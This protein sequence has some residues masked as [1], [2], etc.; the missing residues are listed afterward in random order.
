MLWLLFFR[1][2]N[3]VDGLTYAEQLRR[4]YNLVPFYT[5]SN[6]WQVVTRYTNYSVLFHCF[7]N[8]NG[9]VLL[10]IPAGYMMPRLFKK[11]RNYFRFFATG[12]GVMFLVE[13]LQLFTLLGSFDVDDLILNLFGMSIG[14]IIY[15]YLWKK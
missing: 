11:M 8:L 10:F 7:I 14:F 1:S 6:Y 15:H 4:N 2:P 5:I 3:W 12:L 9:N 13:V